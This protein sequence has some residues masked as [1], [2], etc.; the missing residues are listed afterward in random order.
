MTEEHSNIKEA[1]DLLKL[2]NKLDPNSTLDLEIEWHMKIKQNGGVQKAL[3]VL[4]SC[5][6]FLS[7]VLLIMKSVNDIVTVAKNSES[8][9]SANLTA[10]VSPPINLP[11]V[12][13]NFKGTESDTSIDTDKY[14]TVENQS[15]ET[16][17]KRQKRLSSFTSQ[18]RNTNTAIPDHGASCSHTIISHNFITNLK[19][20]I[21]L[22]WESDIPSR[23]S[24]ENIPGAYYQ[25]I[26]K[27]T[28][29]NLEDMFFNPSDSRLSWFTKGGISD[30][31][32]F[33]PNQ[34][35]FLSPSI[36]EN[37]D[38]ISLFFN[39]EI[40]FGIF[41]V[42]FELNQFVCLNTMAVTI[43]TN[44]FMDNLEWSAL[45]TTSDIPITN[46][47]LIDDKIGA[48]YENI[49]RHNIWV[50]RKFW[51][52]KMWVVWIVLKLLLNLVDEKIKSER[53]T[54]ENSTTNNTKGKAAFHVPNLGQFNK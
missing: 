9:M 41:P 49:E 2:A 42:N 29:N 39:D 52:C 32:S 38:L 20:F 22:S 16:S 6:P 30:T 15:V 13:E 36:K 27:F 28:K 8:D 33:Y 25:N 50:Y 14:V 19:E 26:F 3:T 47:Y 44:K 48:W 10:Q 12:C 11:N 17:S 34:I 46:Y 21:D 4:N 31:I 23:M 18:T 40:P 37:K 54:I 51:T 7:K 1:E 35:R 24:A 53:T 43:F 5:K 45:K